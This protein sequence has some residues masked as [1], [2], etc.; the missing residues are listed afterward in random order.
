MRKVEREKSHF[1]RVDAAI[2]AEASARIEGVT[3][4]AESKLILR[5]WAE[6]ECSSE[7]LD[8]WIQKQNQVVTRQSES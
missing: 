2:H 3:L 7:E 8:D 1:T 5:R 4:D 6:G